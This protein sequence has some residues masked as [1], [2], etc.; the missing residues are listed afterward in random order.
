MNAILTFTIASISGK[1]YAAMSAIGNFLTPLHQCGGVCGSAPLQFVV[2]DAGGTGAIFDLAA[3]TVMVL[4]VVLL[5]VVAPLV[6]VR[7]PPEIRLAGIVALVGSAAFVWCAAVLNFLVWPR[8]FS[9]TPLR[10]TIIA[11]LAMAGFT[12][13]VRA[14]IIRRDSKRVRV[15]RSSTTKK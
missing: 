2:R 13:A 8:P 10:C 3:M 1:S 9:E 15:S 4:I 5:A 12:V 11:Y 6:T 7:R 14:I